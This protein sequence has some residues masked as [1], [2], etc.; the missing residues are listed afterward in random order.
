MSTSVCILCSMDQG[1]IG[2]LSIRENLEESLKFRVGRRKIKKK[3]LFFSFCCH[4]HELL[5]N[6]LK[7]KYIII[8]IYQNLHGITHNLKNNPG[9]IWGKC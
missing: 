9:K 6:F 7:C 8:N 4:L 2:Q 1:W 5:C 3:K